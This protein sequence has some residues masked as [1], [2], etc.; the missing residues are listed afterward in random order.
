LYSWYSCF[1]I[2]IQ[3]LDSHGS[4]KSAWT[5]KW[6]MFKV[7]LLRPSKIMTIVAQPRSLP[8]ASGYSASGYCFSKNI[9]CLYGR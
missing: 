9:H 3:C 1:Y 7:K 2:R 6:C 5:I 8:R 4:R